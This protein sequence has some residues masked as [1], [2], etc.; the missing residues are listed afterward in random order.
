[1]Q[2]L[3]RCLHRLNNKDKYFQIFCSDFQYF[4]QVIAVKFLNVSSLKKLLS[5][6]KVIK[7]ID[8]CSSFI[9]I[10]VELPLK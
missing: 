10:F 9:I 4:H 2:H 6:F 8:N 5:R 3:L 7:K 1:M